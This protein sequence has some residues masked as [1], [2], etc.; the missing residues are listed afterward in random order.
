MLRRSFVLG[1][2]AAAAVIGLVQG[3]VP[4]ASL[5]ADRFIT[6]ASTTSTEDSGLFGSILPKFTAKTGIE[7]RV[8]AKGTGQAIDLAK[9]GDA[10]VLF[11]HHKPSEE[12][13]VAEGFSTVRKPV[14]YND[15][16][17]VGPA[18]DP[19]GIKGSKDVAA[20]LGKIAGAKAPFV[21]RGDDSGTHKA[22]LALW[23]TASL[24]P[25]KADGGWYKSIGQGMGPTLNTAAAMN[26]YT[27]TDRGTWLNF[28]NRG[29][30]TILVE[31]DKRLFNQYGVMLVN[32]AK[33]SHV[34][35]TDGQAFVDWLVSAE[36]QQAIADYKING[37]QL[38]FPNANEPGA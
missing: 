9:R 8:V 28:K 37:E 10:D 7:V 12:K 11:V 21:S 22:E 3:A 4:S 1:C 15:F 20:S 29:P 23:K 36:G 2:A 31:G 6:V 27:L 38:F 14:M 24:D 30:L 5:A 33:F 26:G 13:F 35:A 19:A 25:A 18:V 32:P 16:V 17:I 34:K